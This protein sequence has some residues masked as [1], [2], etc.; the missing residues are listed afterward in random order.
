MG[1]RGSL[2]G[3]V[4]AIITAA[5]FGVSTPLAKLLLADIGPIL[6]AGL[7]YL[8]SGLGLFFLGRLRRSG[9]R[10]PR[11]AA[12]DACDYPWL[13]GAIIAGGVLAPIILFFGLRET[14]AATASLLLTVELAA[15]ALIAS[16][17]FSEF[18]GKRALIAI[19]G[20]A[21]ASIVLSGGPAGLPG[22]SLPAIGIII[23]C[24]FWGIDNNLTRKISGKDP[25]AIAAAKGLVAGGISTVIALL[26][27]ITLP[28]WSIIIVS[29]AIGFFTYGLS[30]VFFVRSLRDLGA[31]RTSAY[32][33]AAPF[34]GSIASVLIIREIP[35][36]RF[37]IALPVFLAGAILLVSERHVHS[38]VHERLLHIHRHRHEEHHDHP[39]PGEDTD[40]HTHEHLHEPIEHEHPHT[41]DIH[42]RH[43]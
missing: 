1:I 7:L 2:K 31:A 29:L 16:L 20:I 9:K 18:I 33:A 6:L 10:V 34:I 14:P 23:A 15:T 11:E 27:G 40:D 35:D 32:F 5:L 42:H 38:H 39:H 17:V 26:A 8:G 19:A 13:G 3:P 21:A 43:G 25:L 30:I 37:F 12:L 22:L 28:D 4:S 36:I 24:V 41:P